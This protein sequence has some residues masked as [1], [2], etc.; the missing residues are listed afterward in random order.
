MAGDG[1]QHSTAWA[2]AGNA[3]LFYDPT[4]KGELT[5]AN[6]IMFTD[7]DP[8]ARDDMQALEDVFD[9]N[10]DGKLDAGDA[11]F[12]DFFVEVTN[13]RWN[14]HDREPRA[15]RNQFDQSRTQCGPQGAAGRLLDRRRDDLY[16]DKRRDT[17]RRR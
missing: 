9:T 17:R 1:Y 12:K 5:R 6:Q 13:A 14:L 2:G 11:C 7:W 15:G 4:G 10:H 8:G 16:D 3:V